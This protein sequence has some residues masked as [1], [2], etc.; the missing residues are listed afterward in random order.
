VSSKITGRLPSDYRTRLGDI[1]FTL[2]PAGSI[3]GAPKRK[4]VEIILENELDP[5]GYYT[6]IFGIYDGETLDSG[7]MIRF[8]EQR[9]GSLIYRSGGGITAWSDPEMEYQ[10]L[11]DKIY[12]PLA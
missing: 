10:E 4:T 12:V 11:I 8:I 1:I 5:R 3:C 6:G 9:D 2:L 7:V